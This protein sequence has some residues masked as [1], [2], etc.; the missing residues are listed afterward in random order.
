MKTN[1]PVEANGKKTEPFITI[2]STKH[3][4]NGGIVWGCKAEDR[5]ASEKGEYPFREEFPNKY[6]GGSGLGHL[7]RD[8][9]SATYAPKTK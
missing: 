8:R 7:F 5:Q 4:T 6:A 1:L 2:S 3:S 9:Q